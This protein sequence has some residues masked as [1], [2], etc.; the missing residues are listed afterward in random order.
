M[1]LCTCAK[2]LKCFEVLVTVLGFLQL[3]SSQ[4]IIGEG[5]LEIHCYNIYV[6]HQG[7]QMDKQCIVL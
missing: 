4:S 6:S 1:V 5:C 2:N 3:P 7:Y